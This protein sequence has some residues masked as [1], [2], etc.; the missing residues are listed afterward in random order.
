MV[1][2]GFYKNYLFQRIAYIFILLILCLISIQIGAKDFSIAGLLKNNTEDTFILI[3]SRLPRVL[4]IIITGAGLSIAGLIMQTITNNRFVAPSTAGTMEWCKL[5]V[6]IAIMFFG[7][8]SQYLKI[9]VAFIVALIGNVIFMTILRNIKFKNALMLPLI[10]MMMGSV[11]SSLTTFFAYKFDLVQNISSWLQGSF[12]LVIKGSYEIL[13][14]GI[15]CVIIAYIFANKFTIASMGEEMA[16]NLGLDYKK[17]V[18]IGMAIVSFITSLI[19]VTIGSI[20]FV[21]LII[22]NIITMIKGDSIKNTLFDTAIFGAIFVLFCDIIGRILIYPYEV[23][24]STVI[25]VFGSII[26]LIILLKK[27]K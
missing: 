12:S 3:I 1:T 7:S 23:S 17:V 15:I 11:V 18:A 2:K 22:P 5:G 24:V 19:V 21:G 14:I 13:Y 9:I 27:E 26:F 6:L 10:G 8:S 25:S 4:S 16:V 20:S